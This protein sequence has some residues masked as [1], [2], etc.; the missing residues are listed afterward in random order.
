MGLNRPAF[1]NRG[2][3]YTTLGV[4]MRCGKTGGRIGTMTNTVHYRADGSVT[5]R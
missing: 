4:T 2:K 1:S 3:G 5:L